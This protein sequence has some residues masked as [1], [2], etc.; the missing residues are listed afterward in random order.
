MKKYCLLLN[1]Q[2]E[3][4]HN[5]NDNTSIQNNQ[6]SCEPASIN[7]SNQIFTGYHPILEEALC[8]SISI[9]LFENASYDSYINEH[10]FYDNNNKKIM[11]NSNN[12]ISLPVC[13]KK[14]KWELISQNNPIFG[15]TLNIPSSTIAIDA[16]YYNTYS[17]LHNYN[18]Y[19]PNKAH[20]FGEN[21][22][23]AKNP[24]GSYDRDE[25]KEQKLFAKGQVSVPD[26]EILPSYGNI[27]LQVKYTDGKYVYAKKDIFISVELKEILIGTDTGNVPFE[28]TN[29][30]ICEEINKNNELPTPAVIKC[31][32]NN[33]ALNDLAKLNFKDLNKAGFSFE[34]YNS[35]NEKDSTFNGSISKT[36]NIGFL[37]NSLTEKFPCFELQISY[38]P[39]IKYWNYTDDGN[40]TLKVLKNSKEVHSIGISL[41]KTLY[42]NTADPE[43]EASS[44][45]LNKAN[46]FETTYTISIKN[47]KLAQVENYR[48][49]K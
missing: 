26:G 38:D 27:T 16:S 25:L 20:E 34:C 24:A 9:N 22:D 39:Q 45:E 36:F 30:I 37:N 1:G 41:D 28:I 47:P 12:A 19:W 33:I 18:N 14:C 17:G 11:H 7:L 46:N 35:K 5:S 42:Y 3:I 23:P 21:P 32:Y 15:V 4:K 29:K 13:S 44:I 10:D 6:I 31:F 8:P 43:I 2:I 49:C 40:Y 48:M